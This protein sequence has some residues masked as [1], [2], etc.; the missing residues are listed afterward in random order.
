MSLCVQGQLPFCK[1]VMY[2]LLPLVRKGEEH[3]TKAQLACSPTESV[4]N[5]LP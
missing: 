4:F 3:C 5:S 2:K 1:S